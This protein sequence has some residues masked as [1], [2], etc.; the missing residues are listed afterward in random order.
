M[1]ISH[2]CM[3]VLDELH[4]SILYLFICMFMSDETSS[5]MEMITFWK[6]YLILF[7]TRTYPRVCLRYSYTHT[8]THENAILVIVVVAVAKKYENIFLLL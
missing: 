1:K 5:S 2:A 7:Y 4:L 6:V 3:C 8:Q